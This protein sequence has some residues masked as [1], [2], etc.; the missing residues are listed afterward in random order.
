[1]CIR[2]RYEGEFLTLLGSSGCGKTTTLRIIAGFETPTEG[3][4]YI[5]DKDVTEPVSYT[6]LGAGTYTGM[7]I[8]RAWLWNGTGCWTYALTEGARREDGG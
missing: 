4:V 1:M 8:Y 3:N 5:E 2:D 6:H 7:W